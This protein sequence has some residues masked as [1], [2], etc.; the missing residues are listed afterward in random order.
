MKKIRR[1]LL[2][3]VLS[4]IILTGC[5]GVHAPVSGLL[6]TEVR[7]PITATDNPTYSKKGKGSCG[8]LLGLFAFGDA[9]I[10]TAVKRAGITKIHHI[11]YECFSL[12]G[13]Y[14][15]YTVYVFGE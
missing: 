15:S 6:V 7:G 10:H 14:S 13:I 2:L 4:A 5:A 1:Y 8:S 3:A 12:F 9:S 11:D